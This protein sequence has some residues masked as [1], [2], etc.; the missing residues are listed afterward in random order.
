MKTARLQAHFARKREEEQHKIETST[1]AQKYYDKWG[2]ITSRHEN[3]STPEYYE[4]NEA[5]HAKRLE[6]E[7]KQKRLVERQEKLRTLLNEEKK[8]YEIAMKG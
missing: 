1:A 3:W 6:L 7:E 5:K 2:R 8:I 4:K